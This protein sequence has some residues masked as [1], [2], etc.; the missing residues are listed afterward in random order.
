MRRCLLVWALSIVLCCMFL[1]LFARLK[2]DLMRVGCKWWGMHSKCNLKIG[3][4]C[5]SGHKGIFNKVQ[6]RSFSILSEHTG[7][8]CP[9]KERLQVVQI[10]IFRIVRLGRIKR[11]EQ[12]HCCTNHV[13]I[14]PKL[15]QNWWRC[16]RLGDGN[17]NWFAP[18]TR[19]W[20]WPPFP[21]W[22]NPEFAP[23]LWGSPTLQR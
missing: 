10:Y 20:S 12:L 17:T 23:V 19:F 16:G 6:F 14:G 3:T 22:W 8:G 15:A 4:D 11:V 7:D 1:C 21:L 9:E 5:L 13:E 2:C 18:L